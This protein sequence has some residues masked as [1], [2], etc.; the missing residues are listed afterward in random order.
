[1]HWAVKTALAIGSITAL[2]FL[3]FLVVKLAGP[4]MRAARDAAIASDCEKNLISIGQAI[5]DYYIENG[6]YPP[7]VVRDENGK[8]MHSWRVLILPFL[9]PEA[10]STFSKY[11]MNKPWDAVENRDCLVEMPPEFRCPADTTLAQDE[12]SYLAIV[13]DR[14]VINKSGETVRSGSGTFVLTDQP[15]ET[16]VVVEAV[17]CGVVWLEPRDIPVSTLRAGLNGSNAVGPAS[18]HPQG[19]STLMADGSVFRLPEE[20]TPEELKGMATIDGDEYMPVLEELLF[21]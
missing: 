4:V 21:E 7:A 9:G 14:T 5:E 13:G 8:P 2:C 15:T 1:M 17:N 18:L 20:T 16:M 19:V 3:G 10:Q 12:T 11:D 6:H